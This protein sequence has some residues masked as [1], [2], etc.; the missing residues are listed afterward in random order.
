MTPHEVIPA[1]MG[2]LAWLLRD[3]ENATPGDSD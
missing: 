2:M 3:D 1:F